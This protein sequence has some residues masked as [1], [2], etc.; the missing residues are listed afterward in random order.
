MSNQNENDAQKLELYKKRLQQQGF[1]EKD[2]Q[3]I[4]EVIV[5][6][7]GSVKQ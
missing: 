5:E 3:K 4:L 1:N 2:V 6:M 7:H